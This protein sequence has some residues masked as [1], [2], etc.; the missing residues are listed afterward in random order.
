MRGTEQQPI[1][2]ITWYGA[3]AYSLWANR[4]DWRR[5]RGDN[6][7][8]SELQDRVVDAEMPSVEWLGSFLPSEAQWEYAARGGGDAALSV[9]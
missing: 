5:Y 7:I 9:G 4:R 1:I 3:N 2:L 6:T 8:P